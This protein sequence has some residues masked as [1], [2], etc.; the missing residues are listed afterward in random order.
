MRTLYPDPDMSDHVLPHI[1]LGQREVADL[2]DPERWIA[3]R[4]IRIFGH[5][6]FYWSLGKKDRVGGIRTCGTHAV[7]TPRVRWIGRAAKTLI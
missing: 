5:V 1:G 4:P 3:C 6:A 2:I 7:M